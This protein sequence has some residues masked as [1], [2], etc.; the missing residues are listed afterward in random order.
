MKNIKTLLPIIL[1]FSLSLGVCN[2]FSF[3]GDFN[4]QTSSGGIVHFGRDITAARWDQW[5]A[6][7]R[8]TGIVWNGVDF[9]AVDA[10]TG[11]TVNF[12]SLQQRVLVYSVTDVGAG[13]QTINYR[14]LGE[15]TDVAGGTYEMNGDNVVVSTTGNVVVTLSWVTPLLQQANQILQM[16]GVFMMVPIMLG[17]LG[18]RGVLEGSIDQDDFTKLVYGVVTVVVVIFTIGLL[19][20]SMAG[21]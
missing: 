19:V 7:T 16:L 13:T 11:T 6:L 5:G 1:L 21:A 20:K 15:P 3:G 14:G 18:V 17:A 4:Y 10:P 9:L 8:F 12:T 2:A